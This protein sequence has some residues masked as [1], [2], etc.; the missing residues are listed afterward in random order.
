MAFGIMLSVIAVLAA[1]LTLF[2]AVLGKL[3]TNINKGTIR[4]GRR[5]TEGGG[6]AT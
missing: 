5:R 1:T 3:G 2:P 4:L 6:G